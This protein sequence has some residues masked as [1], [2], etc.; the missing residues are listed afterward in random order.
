MPEDKRAMKEFWDSRPCGSSTSSK[1]PGTREFFDEAESYRYEVEPC[2]LEY[3]KFDQTQG[4]T[5][6]EIGVGMG[7]DSLQFVRHG[8]RFIGID[9]SS[10]S[11]RLTQERFRLYGCVGS[12]L[13][14]D[15]ECLPFAANLFDVIYSWGV[16]LCIPNI[17]SAV[18][19]VRRVLR[20]GGQA[21]V[22]LYHR[23]SLNYW[24]SIM[25]IRRVAYRLL[26]TRIGFSIV[27]GFSRIDATLRA[28]LDR[29]GSLLAFKKELDRKKVLTRQEI[30]NMST[31][32][33]GL[34]YTSVFSKREARALFAGFS[35]VKT[36]V[37][38]LYEQNL[39]FGRFLPGRM[40]GWF[41]SAWG[42]FLVV[43]AIK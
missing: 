38:C 9:L 36:S 19:E 30:L 15:A 42:W 26:R 35:K 24:L 13:Q 43:E 29:T 7:T 5:V 33:P 12:L 23:N 32:G 11:L 10:R 17:R 31:D 8:A 16:L 20:P 2:I 14:A 40:K 34:P 21:I 3:A 41:G 1:T 18:E 28:K 25:L 6:L 39:P 27:D 37:C 22:M 4:K